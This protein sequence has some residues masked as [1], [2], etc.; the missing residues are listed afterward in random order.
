MP[1]ME[2]TR[3]MHTCAVQLFTLRCME[4]RHISLMSNMRCHDVLDSPGLAKLLFFRLFQSRVVCC[5][6]P[7][8]VVGGR[9]SRLEHSV[10]PYDRPP[11]GS[12]S[13]SPSEQRFCL[14][15]AGTQCAGRRIVSALYA[16]CG[17]NTGGFRSVWQ[18][19]PQL[20]ES[21]MEGLSISL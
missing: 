8:V 14:D 12:A 9:A 6:Q 10:F 21:G 19:P 7:A 16:G 15:S 5:A 4:C 17:S 20:R 2:N 11:R 1:N 13:F 3:H 18:N